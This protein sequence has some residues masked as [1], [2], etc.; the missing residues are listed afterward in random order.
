MNN[1][2]LLFRTSG[3]Q[4]RTEVITVT[5]RGFVI[6]MILGPISISISKQCKKGLSNNYKPKFLEWLRY[7]KIHFTTCQCEIW[8]WLMYWQTWLTTKDMLGLIKDKYWELLSI[9]W[10]QCESSMKQPLKTFKDSDMAI[11]VE[12]DLETCIFVRSNKLEMYL[13]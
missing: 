11:R 9:L 3:K 6:I 12:T 5:T 2:G 8:G 4:V 13:D 10:N 1:N 7:L